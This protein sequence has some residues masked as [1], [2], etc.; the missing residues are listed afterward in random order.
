MQLND[1]TNDTGIIQDCYFYLNGITTTQYSSKDVK[2]NINNWYRKSM[3]WVLASMDDWDF[4][5]TSATADLVADQ[6][7][8]TFKTSGDF[9]ITDVIKIHRVE[10]SYDGTNWYRCRK[11]TQDDYLRAI[12]ETSNVGDDFDSTAPFYDLKTDSLDLYPIPQSNGTNQ[13]KLFYKQDLTDLSADGD[14]PIISPEFHRILSI[15]AAYDWAVSRNLPEANPL[16]QEIEQLKQE[17]KNH[18]STR[19]LDNNTVMGKMNKNYK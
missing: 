16:R 2:R 17:L 4:S 3:A 10:V 11:F 15:G 9:N 8:Y 13:L 6:Q 14:V 1:T 7:N 18:Y 19:A 12:T 5:D